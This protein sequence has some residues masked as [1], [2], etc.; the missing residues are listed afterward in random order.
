M[1]PDQVLR[2]KEGGAQDPAQQMVCRGRLTQGW[3]GNGAGSDVTPHLRCGGAPLGEH[4]PQL[5]LE[6]VVQDQLACSYCWQGV[7]VKW[8]GPGA[9]L[10]GGAADATA[11]LVLPLPQHA[12][13]N[14]RLPTM[15]MRSQPPPPHLTAW[16]SG[17][18]CC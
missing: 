2:P 7:N 3:P 11:L 6:V 5:V 14:A 12:L 9:G 15:L 17:S 16:R 10:T 13:L 4:V 8:P 1:W 18:P